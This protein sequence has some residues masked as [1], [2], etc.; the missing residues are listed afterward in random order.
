MYTSKYFGVEMFMFKSFLKRL[1][2]QKSL[3]SVFAS[4][5]SC[6][7]F[8]LSTSSSIF[9]SHRLKFTF[10]LLSSYFEIEKKERWRIRWVQKQRYNNKQQSA[11]AR[12]PK[13][14]ECKHGNRFNKIKFTV[15]LCAYWIHTYTIMCAMRAQFVGFCGLKVKTLAWLLLPVVD[16]LFLYSRYVCCTLRWIVHCIL[17]LC[18]CVQCVYIYIFYFIIYSSFGFHWSIFAV[19]S[20]SSIDDNIELKKKMKEKRRNE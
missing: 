7:Q 10:N 1:A 18:V 20:L 6:F 19:L 17:C 12:T 8:I 14:F 13:T 4:I 3:F 15:L 11:R 2:L 5:F 9:W 16:V